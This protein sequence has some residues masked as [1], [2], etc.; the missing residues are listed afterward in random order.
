MNT[1]EKS[2]M[3][4][5]LFTVVALLLVIVAILLL[6]TF[7]LLF[8]IKQWE[9]ATL[10]IGYLEVDAVSFTVFTDRGKERIS[11]EDVRPI[12]IDLYGCIEVYAFN[13]MGKE[14]W[15]LAGY[16]EGGYVFRR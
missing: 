6:Q 9:Y 13:Y 1:F 4:L 11:T 8:T 3:A 14:G 7:P 2:V 15:Q 16:Y 10:V 12:N 5:L